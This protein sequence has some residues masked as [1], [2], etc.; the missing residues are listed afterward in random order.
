MYGFLRIIGVIL[1]GL[2]YGAAAIIGVHLAIALL[3]PHGWPLWPFVLIIIGG[4]AAR[5]RRRRVLAILEHLRTALGLNLPLPPTLDAAARSESGRLRERLQDIGRSVQAGRTLAQAVEESVPEMPRRDQ[6]VLRAAEGVGRLPQA[7]DR[8]VRQRRT[9]NRIE[10]SQSGMVWAY[11]VVLITMMFLLV[12]F[13]LIFVVPSFTKIFDDFGTALPAPTQL[14]IDASHWLL[15]SLDPNTSY[16]E[17]FVVPGLAWIGLGLLAIGAAT[18]LLW[19]LGLMRALLD[20]LAWHL[21]VFRGVARDRGLGDVC[22]VLLESLDAGL[23][24]DR[25]LAQAAELNVNRIQ[26]RRLARWARAVSAGQPLDQAARAAKLPPL[27]VGVL[28]SAQ[29]GADLKGMF[30]FLGR[31]YDTCF[32]RAAAVL[33]GAWIPGIVLSLA[34]VEGLIV[35]SLFL[36][37]VCLILTVATVKVRP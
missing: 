15:G 21:P 16:N 30:R 17:A 14:V 7:L 1:A 29:A 34:L 25:A 5:L 10:D 33:R 12:V 26:K 35:V 6:S 9:A 24:I 3:I 28:A 11:P 31:H 27:L 37:L 18:L 13:M 23:P 8:L 36:P 2:L 32:S 22:H 4:T 19:K 20:T